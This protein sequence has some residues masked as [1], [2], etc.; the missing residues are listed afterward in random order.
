MKRRGQVVQQATQRE[1]EAEKERMISHR[2]GE[3]FKYLPPQKKKNI[4]IHV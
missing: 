3:V 1:R 4:Y 2:K